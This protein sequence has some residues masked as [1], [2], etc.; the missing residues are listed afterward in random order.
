MPLEWFPQLAAVEIAGA[1]GLLAGL[2]VPAIG[3]AAA[4]GVILYYIH[5]VSFHVRAHDTAL[6]PPV[7]IGLLGVGALVLRLASV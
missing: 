2:F 5:A 1:I 3:V 7:V 6:V 4:I